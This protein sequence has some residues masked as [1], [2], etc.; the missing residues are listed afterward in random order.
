MKKEQ[1]IK[2]CKACGKELDTSA[3]ICPQCGKD[4]RNFFIKH[5][6][7]TGIIVLLIIGIFGGD[8]DN[9]N[10]DTATTSTKQEKTIDTSSTDTEQEQTTD[11]D[12]VDTDSVDKN[13]EESL[14]ED[15]DV[16]KENVIVVDAT[17][18]YSYY[19]SNEVK[20]DKEYKDKLIEVTGRVTDIGVSLG[21]TYVCL[22]TGDA[23]S[24]FSI[25]CF[26]D[27][28]EQIDKVSELNNGDTI[29]LNGTCVGMSMNV[30]LNDC[31]L[32]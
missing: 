29:T 13:K 24:L 23:Y 20:A 30:V 9:E 12:S 3:K 28:D 21:Q 27:D 10:I 18:L 11:T 25:Q 5:K 4:Q 14:T 22:S 2:Y 31:K 32:K 7:L 8:G 1:K 17:K 26:F 16:E 15:I 6:I 19:D